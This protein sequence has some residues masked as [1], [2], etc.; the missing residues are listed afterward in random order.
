MSAFVE[1]LVEDFADKEFAHGYM[2]DHGNSIIAAQIKVLREQRGLSQEE[3]AVLAGMKQERISK[4][5]NVTYDAWTVKTLRKLAEAFD[6]HL[7]VQFVPF[8][9]AVMDVVNLDRK[10]L[11]V[12]PREKDLKHFGQRSLIKRDGKWNS[13]DIG[14]LATVHE[15]APQATVDPSGR[16]WQP[17]TIRAVR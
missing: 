9:E 2:E 4:L 6:V 16:D 1:R 8:S 15:M 7:K 14:H 12:A 3:L 17:L 10:R 5:E 13:I 11:Q